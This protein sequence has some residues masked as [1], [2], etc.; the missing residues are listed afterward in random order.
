MVAEHLH[1][2]GQLIARVVDAGEQQIRDEVQDF[3][4]REP[5]TVCFCANEFGDQIIG[6]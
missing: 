2:G 6:R 3:A 5:C 1:R 4:A